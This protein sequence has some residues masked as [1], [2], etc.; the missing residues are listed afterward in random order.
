MIFRVLISAALLV[1]GVYWAGSMMM[2]RD[3]CVQ[4]EIAAAPVRVVMRAARTLDS[5]FQFVADR[6]TWLSWS[7]TADKAAQKI[8]IRGI[9]GDRLTCDHDQPTENAAIVPDGSTDYE[10]NQRGF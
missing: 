9:Y 5:N 10:F 1:V 3:R 6:L 8:L 2:E 4:I 7:V